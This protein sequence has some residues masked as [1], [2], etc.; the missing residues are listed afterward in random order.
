M[1]NR[2]IRDIVFGIEDGMVST[3]GA[4]TGI[5]V[6]ANSIE[7]VIVAGL[8]VIS[9]ESVSM[10]IGS[11]IS[12][13]SVRDVQSYILSSEQVEL[14]QMPLAEKAELV[15]LYVHDGWPTALAQ[16]MAETAAQNP[17]LFLLEMS[18]REHGISPKKLEQPIRN[19]IAM[20]ISY[21]IGGVVPLASYLFFSLPVA[22][23]ISIAVTL[24]GLLLLGASTARLTGGHGWRRGL[25]VLLLGGIAGSIGYIVGYL[26][27]LII[28]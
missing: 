20:L 25:Q 26:G 19:A 2:Q 16:T 3:F 14:E 8:I 17:K 22:T 9:V 28:G 11:Y 4:V 24:L 13:Q 27:R 12:S 7:T 21:L 6:A 15:G 23:V 5:A 18:Y 1:F 10:S